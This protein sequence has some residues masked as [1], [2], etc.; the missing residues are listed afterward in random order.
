M[1][2]PTTGQR[3][4]TLRGPNNK[5]YRSSTPG[6][7]GGHRGGRLYGR[8]D[9]PSALRAMG[10]GPYVQYRVFFADDGNAT[11]AGYRSCAVCLPTRYQ[12]W[13]ATQKNRNSAS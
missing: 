13:K 7:L 2:D 8:L 1:T 11:A 10:R 6:T 4:Y 3:T 12:R 9:C 5:P